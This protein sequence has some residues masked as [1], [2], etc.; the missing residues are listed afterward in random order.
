LAAS[1]L[2][3]GKATRL[4]GRPK[5]HIELPDGRTLIARLIGVVREVGIDEVVISANDS[6]PY[7]HLGLP[8][9][10][11]RR[12]D[13]GPLAGIEAAL[14]Y[15]AGMAEAVV[16]LSTD[17]SSLRAGHLSALLSAV[18]EDL[19]VV[20]ACI[21]AGEHDKECRVEPLVA[22]VSTALRDTLTEFLDQG[23][24]RVRDFYAAHSPVI[25]PLPASALTNINT[26][27]D[28]T[29]LSRPHT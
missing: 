10:A 3:G 8:V 15:F 24:R 25:V 27:E 20:C 2:A 4:G 22:V 9:I 12:S 29:G 5:G 16:V 1:I 14:H 11:D 17:L 21:R 19:T 6:A 23:G 18:P 28:L 26:P 7:Q 13:A